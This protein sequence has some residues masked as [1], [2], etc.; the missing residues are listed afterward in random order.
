MGSR[1]L[2]CSRCG[3]DLDEGEFWLNR[4]RPRGRTDYCKAC[5]RAYKREWARRKRRSRYNGSAPGQI[6]DL[7][8]TDGGWWTPEAI[9]DRLELAVDHTK[10]TMYRLRDKG[11]VRS[12][13]RELNGV[14]KDPSEW[15]ST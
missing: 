5:S 11:E 9:A 10:R 12:R 15:S 8:E 3:E 4:T 7:L 6:L 1:L 14:L 13:R 2:R